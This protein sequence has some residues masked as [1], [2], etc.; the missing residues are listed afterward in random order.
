MI[1]QFEPI[2]FSF[3]DFEK[4]VAA[5]R[6]LLGRSN[7]LSEANDISP[8]FK[9]HPQLASL[10]ASI[11]LP[12]N[13]D[14]ICSE[15]DLFGNFRCDWAVGSIA[16]QSYA[17]IEFEDARRDSIFATVQKYNNQWSTRFEHGFSQ[18]VDW[19]WVLDHYRDNLDFR[20]RFGVGHIR[21][22]GILVIGRNKFLT[23]EQR[24]RLVWRLDRVSINTHKV[25]CITFDDLLDFFAK[26]LAFLKGFRGEP[27]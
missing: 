14:R 24:Q 11:V 7:E 26:R 21:F 17:L 18:I 10:I 22:H 12:H 16:D 5:F 13:I 19:F 4:G 23:H 6:A 8:F 3:S 15:F 2:A 27:S 1:K 25:S 20:R 9:S